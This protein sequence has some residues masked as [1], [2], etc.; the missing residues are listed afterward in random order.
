MSVFVHLLNTHMED[1]GPCLLK[2]ELALLQALA[3]ALAQALTKALT[4][5]LTQALDYYSESVKIV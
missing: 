2:H 1:L 4:Q 3:Q 5:A